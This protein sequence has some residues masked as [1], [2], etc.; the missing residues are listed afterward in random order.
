[1]ST[2]LV[3]LPR[4]IFSFAPHASL[5]LVVFRHE[6]VPLLS[7][8]LHVLTAVSVSGCVIQWCRWVCDTVVSVGVMFVL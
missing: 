6:D 2:M 7:V 8:P 1:M 3:D 4:R 5:H